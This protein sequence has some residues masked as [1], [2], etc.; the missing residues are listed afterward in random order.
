MGIKKCL[1]IISDVRTRNFENYVGK[2]TMIICSL[3][4]I[5]FIHDLKLLGIC[6]PFQ[7]FVIVIII[8]FNLLYSR[9]IAHF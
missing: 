2:E 9:F 4:Q 1:L 6:N 3:F 8:H 7:S 5:R